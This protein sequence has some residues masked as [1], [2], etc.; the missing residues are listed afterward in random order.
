MLTDS[1]LLYYFTVCLLVNKLNEK[2]Y[3]LV[4]AITVLIQTTN[5]SELFYLTCPMKPNRCQ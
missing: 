4:E 1:I 3:L 5:S 2:N